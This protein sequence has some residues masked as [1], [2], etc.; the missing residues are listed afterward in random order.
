[1]TPTNPRPQTQRYV[2]QDAPQHSGDCYRTALAI[3]LGLDRDDV[4]H[5]VQLARADIHNDWWNPTIDWL[6]ERGWSI[7]YIGATDVLSGAQRLPK[8]GWFIANGLTRRS[9]DHLKSDEP[10]A[11]CYRQ[12]TDGD[13]IHHSVVMRADFEEFIDPHPEGGGLS[14]VQSFYVVTRTDQHARID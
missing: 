6:D 4:P 7:T 12:L 8:D 14:I 9:L 3:L 11:L 13:P 2:A 10:W 1:M 5:F